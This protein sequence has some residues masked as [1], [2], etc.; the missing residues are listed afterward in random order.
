MAYEVYFYALFIVILYILIVYIL[1]KNKILKKLNISFFGPFLMWRTKRGRVFIDKVSQRRRFWN[2]YGI[3]SVIIIII[4]MVLISIIILLGSIAAIDARAKPLPPE[5]I[6]ALPGLNPLIPLWYGIFALAIAVVVHEFAHGI[7]ARF[8]KVKIKSLGI[9]LFIVP[10]GAFVEPDEKQM[11]TVKK[12]HR[13][14]IFST[15]PATNI[16]FGLLC[17]MIFSWCFM[18][19]L[20]PI[21][22][23]VIIFN[24]YEGPTELSTPEIES[25]ME[26]IDING[27]P[28][29]DYS[30][31]YN[32]NG[33]APNETISLGI[34][35]NGEYQR[36]ENITSG[37]T[38]I[39]L[40]E[41]YPAHDAGIGVGMI[42]A[43]VDGHEIRNHRDF[44]DYMDTT[45]PDQEI[46]I[47]A[48]EYMDPV[49][50]NDSS[51]Q[52]GIY[53]PKVFQVKLADKYE[54]YKDKVAIY[55]D[56]KE[57]IEQTKGKGYLGLTTSYLA[58]DV[59]DVNDFSDSLA[60]P[61]I[62]ADSS[63]ER[64]SNIFQ[65]AIGLP[66]DLSSQILPFHSPIID[67]YEV[68]GPL[69]ILPTELFWT[70]AN[71]FYYLFWINILVGTFNALPMKPLDGGYVFK[72]G[73]DSI[74]KRVK[75][76][77]SETKREKYVNMLSNFIAFFFFL[78]I[79]WTLI[80]P[81]IL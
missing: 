21:E 65:Y 12:S 2:I 69:G 70:M 49:Q 81:W 54:Y 74:V 58:L 16:I 46:L 52:I 9:L 29:D 60:Y 24:A 68:K 3:L 42:I 27:E 13:V 41:G 59:R 80:I 43:D 6:L 19:S 56:E 48:L 17:A 79:L 47:T 73:L 64:R 28:I 30:D 8:A 62:S 77:I 78:L 5:Q 38:V 76:G 20:S 10:M 66:M 50:N 4:A 63:F 39:S 32:Y 55:E 61:V 37:L 57:L 67:L 45:K 33:S 18:A 75:R 7:L 1:W 25:G 40:L 34:Y 35:Y 26:I 36:I 11:E 53:V 15:G 14:K 44:A 23:G 31:F 22:D 51:S 72:D 71:A